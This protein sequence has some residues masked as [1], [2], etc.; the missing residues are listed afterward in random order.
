MHLTS[1]SYSFLHLSTHY[2]DVTDDMLPKLFE[3]T[4][5]SCMH[6][7]FSSTY[8]C[9]SWT[10]SYVYDPILYSILS[11]EITIHIFPIP[12]YKK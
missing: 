2:A 6:N 1:P 10:N 11:V 4:I 5:S 9:D 7:V 8:I 3:I 12:T